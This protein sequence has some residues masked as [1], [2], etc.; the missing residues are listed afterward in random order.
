MSLEL[1]S[2]TNDRVFKEIFTRNKSS[3]ADFLK[4]ILNISNEEFE[5]LEFIDTHSRR[6]SILGGEYILDI[7]VKTKSYIVD[8]EMQVKRSPVMTQR[9]VLYLANMIKDQDLNSINYSNMKKTVSIMIAADHSINSDNRY[10]H[11]YNLREEK[12]NSLFTDLI[13]VDI[14]ELKK[15]PD[16]YDGSP[17][18]DWLTFI[19]TNNEETMKMLSEKNPEIEKAYDTLIDMSGDEGERHA[20]QQREMYLQNEA[21][22]NKERFEQGLKK[23]LE[24]GQKKEKIEIAKNAIKMNLDVQSIAKLTGLTENEI[25]DLK[26]E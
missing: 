3:M 2:K 6:G 26:N 25:K 12:D 1:L 5:D 22:I 13:E 19:K 18:W 8:V 10:F 9:I 21:A 17:L 14:L 24:R 23:G 11:R 7:K 16:K 20:S 4:C 15:L